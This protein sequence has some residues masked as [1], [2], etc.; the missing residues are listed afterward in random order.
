MNR[1]CEKAVFQ[2]SQTA[3]GAKPHDGC[4]Q[5]SPQSTGGGASA[6]SFAGRLWREMAH[7]QFKER[8]PCPVATDIAWAF[9]PAVFGSP[10]YTRFTPLPLPRV[11]TPF[12][13]ALP[14]DIC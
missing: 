2:P 9:P 4:P 8:R 3:G 12:R 5:G 6:S 13:S 14:K 1:C 7:Y 11:A 10:Q